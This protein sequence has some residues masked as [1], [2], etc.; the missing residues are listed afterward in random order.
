LKIGGSKLHLSQKSNK[1]KTT[2]KRELPSYFR[3]IN[4]L[5][6]YAQSILEEKGGN[7][8]HSEIEKMMLNEEH[9]AHLSQVVITRTT[10]IVEA[11]ASP[12]DIH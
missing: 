7:L 6:F 8:Q 12:N 10:S 11:G 9:V 4:V 2:L 1:T 3:E 5:L